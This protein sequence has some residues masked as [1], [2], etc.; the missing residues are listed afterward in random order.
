MDLQSITI[1]GPGRRICPLCNEEDS[2]L[3]IDHCFEGGGRERRCICQ[4]R[5]PSAVI[6]QLLSFVQYLLRQTLGRR[7]VNVPALK[8]GEFR[9]GTLIP[10]ADLI[11][12]CLKF[13]G[14]GGGG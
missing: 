4:G 13:G 3:D 5:K 10:V 7:P 6:R 2:D 14:H 11:A 12:C 1:S 9:I 8:V